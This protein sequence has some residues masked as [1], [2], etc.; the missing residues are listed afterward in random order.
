VSRALLL[1]EMLSPDIAEQLRRRGHDVVA[2]TERRELRATSDDDLLTEATKQ[3]RALVTMNIRDL[4]RIDT[5][6]KSEGRPH[7]GI[8]LLPASAFPQDR[9]FVGKVVRAL[10]TALRDGTVPGPDEALFLR[11]PSTVGGR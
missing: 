9:R 3:S 11:P 8:V 1:D 2:V 7:A 6:W 10:D 4:A 5:E